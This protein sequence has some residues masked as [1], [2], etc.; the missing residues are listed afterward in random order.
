MLW[1]IKAAP[2]V[3]YSSSSYSQSG[4]SGSNFAADLGGSL[5]RTVVTQAVVPGVTKSTHSS[6]SFSY[7]SGS[8]G[9]MVGIA[10][11]HQL[12]VNGAEV[13]DHLGETGG[14]TVSRS[15]SFNVS[16]QNGGLGINGAR[17]VLSVA[18]VAA[19]A[20]V[21]TTKTTVT[22]TSNSFNTGGEH[23]S[24]MLSAVGAQTADLS[25]LHD[26]RNTAFSV[27]TPPAPLP[28]TTTT[29]TVVTKSASS[30]NT[31]AEHA[32]SILS[33]V[34][35]Q[36]GGLGITDARR[37]VLSVAAQV[38]PQPLTTVTTTRNA[39][40][41]TNGAAVLGQQAANQLLAQRQLLVSSG[42]G[43]GQMLMNGGNLG[44]ATRTV[45]SS[46]SSSSNSAAAGGSASFARRF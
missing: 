36:T 42:G 18:S 45:T 21:V 3:T 33:A 5:G 8:Q 29:K 2:T 25:A 16:S 30:F 7:S 38:L 14:N 28:V 22:R 23:A 31:G 15:T 32:S 46:F 17:N 6:S 35:A 4:Q 24:S 43:S 10:Q 20:P 40:F 41:S 27:I 37:S 44:Q 12:G 1:S 26:V 34:G 39:S 19:P 11:Q 9:G 13:L